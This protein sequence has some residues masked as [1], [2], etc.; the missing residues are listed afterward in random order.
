[1]ASLRVVATVYG[2]RG[3]FLRTPLNFAALATDNTFQYH[4][5]IAVLKERQ[6]SPRISLEIVKVRLLRSFSDSCVIII[7]RRVMAIR[8]R[9]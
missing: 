2:K 3:P 8:T 7:M 6:P 5:G 4:E 9:A 1:M